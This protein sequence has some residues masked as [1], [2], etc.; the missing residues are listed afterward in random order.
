MIRDVSADGKVRGLPSARHVGF[1]PVQGNEHVCVWDKP[2]LPAHSWL[3]EPMN[4]ASLEKRPTERTGHIPVC[5]CPPTVKVFGET[6]SPKI[7]SAA[8]RAFAGR[9]WS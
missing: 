5:A 4:G 6:Q 3:L 2:E 8:G 9:V 7:L 1:W